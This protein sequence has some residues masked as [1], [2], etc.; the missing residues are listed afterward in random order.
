MENVLV[1]IEDFNFPIDYLTFGMDKDQQV[2]FVE[3]LSI[4]TSQ[5]WIDAENGGMTST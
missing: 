2:S 3:R 1:E 5:M 4:A